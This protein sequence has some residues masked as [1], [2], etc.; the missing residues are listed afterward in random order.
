MSPQAKFHA[1]GLL[2]VVLALALLLWAHLA[3]Q[4]VEADLAAVLARQAELITA[5]RRHAS[6]KAPEA[7]R[8]ALVSR[9][10]ADPAGSRRNAG[11][12]G[13]L[14]RDA[15]LQ[16]AYF[17]ARR[18]NLPSTYGPF[19][20]SLKLSADQARSL[21]DRIMERDEQAF[22]ILS[23]VPDAI[24]STYY[25]GTDPFLHTPFLIASNSEDG[26]P[27]EGTP[28]GQAAAALL[29]QNDASF[30][31]AAT[32][33]LG[34]AG[35][36]QLQQ[37]ERQLPVRDAVDSLGNSVAATATPMNAEQAEQLTQILA[38]ASRTYQRG[39]VARPGEQI[40]WDQAMPQAA[41]ILSPEQLAVLQAQIAPTQSMTQLR[42]A[43]RDAGGMGDTAKLVH[44]I[45]G[46][47]N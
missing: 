43:V 22:D 29:Q 17:A 13:V 44:A 6:P 46:G 2:A 25:G 26:K 4:R 20:R 16:L 1:G 27:V 34:P 41:R 28:D 24:H 36:E 42:N 10:E 11:P 5:A 18:A 14:M 23:S 21:E 15:K 8:S 38:N 19:V 30:Q 32:A 7:L 12:M 37:Y 39:G 33:L 31:Q 35:Y 3:R 47:N 40:N 45:T 9:A